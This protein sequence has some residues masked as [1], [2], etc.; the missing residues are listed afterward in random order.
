MKKI[1]IIT[2]SFS[3]G[4]TNRSLI[5]M[6]GMLNNK[7]LNIEIFSM[8]HTGPYKEIF[9]KYNLLPENKFLT[10]FN[11]FKT[12]TKS[13]KFHMRLVRFFIRLYEKVILQDD[14]KRIYKKAGDKLSKR[15]YDIVISFQEGKSTEFALFIKSPKHIAWVRCNYLKYI[16]IAERDETNIYDKYD[17]IV[18]V[19]NYTAKILKS[20]FPQLEERI[21]AIHNLINY[22]KIIEQSKQS[23]DDNQFKIQPF[24]IVSIGRMDPVKRFD[25]IPE[26]AAK[27][28]KAGIPFAW[29]I[30]GDGAGE[31]EK[32]R[33]KI[34]EYNLSDC[35]ILLG[36]KNNPYPYIKKS[37][38]LVCP[39]LS[40]ACPNVVNE[41]RILHIP[42]ISA[43]FPSATEFINNGTN[44]FV[45]SLD[46]IPEILMQLFFNKKLYETIQNNISDYVYDNSA[47]KS[48]ISMLLYEGNK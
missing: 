24:T 9:Q 26:M 38:V 12:I 10:T 34:A 37:S 23:V 43:D 1:L 13:E 5:N 46:K 31:K 47:I 17:N 45:A 32:I 42:V 8:A 3:H 41:A 22:K 7:D 20:C 40:E 2:P 15:N 18:A 29:Y 48:K 30:I 44:G 21:C 6:L 39:S 33:T 36:E 4:G 14:L 28:K 19:S 27:L 35:V 25:S 11:S 16:E